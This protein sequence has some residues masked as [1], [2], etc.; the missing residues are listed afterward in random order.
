MDP[1]RIGKRG[2]AWLL[3]Q[4]LGSDRVRTGSGRRSKKAHLHAFDEFVHVAWDLSP[5]C[6]LDLQCLVLVLGFPLSSFVVLE[7]R[8]TI[9]SRIGDASKRGRLA[10]DAGTDE[11]GSVVL[12]RAEGAVLNQGGGASGRNLQ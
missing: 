8:G 4:S 6:E 3:E 9:L 7:H 5:R 12:R 2:R 11:V 1:S 10:E